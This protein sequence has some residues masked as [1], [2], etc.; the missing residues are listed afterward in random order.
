MKYRLSFPP[1][2][3]ESDLIADG[4]VGIA[5]LLFYNWADRDIPATL[6][7][8]ME[9]HRDRLIEIG[10]LFPI[11]EDGDEEARPI[12]H[13]SLEHKWNFRCGVC[14]GWW[15]ICDIHPVAGKGTSCPHCLTAQ[16]LG[17]IEIPS[18]IPGVVYGK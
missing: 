18:P 12:A 5:Q 6:F 7:Y 8:Q 3:I 2:F 15:S 10:W 16:M 13:V 9:E 11:P 4:T 14:D 17:P 1:D